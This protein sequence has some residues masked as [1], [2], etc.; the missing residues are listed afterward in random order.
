MC[1]VALEVKKEQTE[2]LENWRTVKLIFWLERIEF[3][4][5]MLY[6]IWGLMIIDEEQRFGVK[7]KETFERTEKQVDVLTLT[8]TPILWR[9]TKTTTFL[10]L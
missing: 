6:L 10:P 3:C 2:T 4:Q 9:R 8:A 7:Y 5:K 1:W